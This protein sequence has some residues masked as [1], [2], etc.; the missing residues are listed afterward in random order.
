MSKIFKITGNYMQ[1]GFW[2]IPTPSFAGELVLCDDGYLRGYCDELYES[3]QPDENRLRFIFGKFG[4]S[5]ESNQNG[6]VFYKLSN[7]ELQAPLLYVIHDFD[8]P[9]DNHWLALQDAL[10]TLDFAFQGK[11]IVSVK[12]L[13]YDEEKYDSIS[14]KF[15]QI[16]KNGNLNEL[17]LLVFDK[18]ASQILK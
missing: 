12:E 10:G 11:A 1:Y 3:E 5:K 8:D 13:E 6:L 9:S 7:Y 16:D 14:E 15:N 2:A 4:V 18:F 17:M